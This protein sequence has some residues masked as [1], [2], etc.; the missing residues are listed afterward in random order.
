MRSEKTYQKSSL[1]DADLQPCDVAKRVMEQMK[2]GIRMAS[3]PELGGLVYIHPATAGL[4]RA[5][6]EAETEVDIIYAGI[7]FRVHDKDGKR[8]F[9]LKDVRDLGTSIGV[10]ELSR[11]AE[12][13]NYTPANMAAMGE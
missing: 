11:I 9:S 1:R 10:S 3:I 5:V 2:E 4:T 8:I 6:H 7:A 12:V 13:V